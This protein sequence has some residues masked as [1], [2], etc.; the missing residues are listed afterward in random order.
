MENLQKKEEPFK[1]DTSNRVEFTLSA[2]DEDLN[3]YHSNNNKNNSNIRY[4]PISIDENINISQRKLYH[5]KENFNTSTSIMNDNINHY[6]FN[7]NISVN[8]SN[9]YNNSVIVYGYDI[10]SKKPKKTGNTFSFFYLNDYPI[11]IL[12]PKCK[13]GIY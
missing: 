13:R 7:L 12:G 4:G 5:D 2:T 8:E 6:I 3:S 1:T 10:K 9:V 11:I